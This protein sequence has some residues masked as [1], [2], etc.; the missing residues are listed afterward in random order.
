MLVTAHTDTEIR[1]V[2]AGGGTGGHLYPAIA[3][4]EALQLKLPT[5]TFTFVGTR[6]GI[7]ARVLRKR[8]ENFRTLWV[9]GF[10]R[11][12]L[13][14]NGFA[15]M[16]LTVSLVQSAIILM[17]IRPH[18]AI[19]TGGFVMGPLLFLAQRMRIPTL[20][21][22]QNSVP[23]L[24]TRKLA[25]RADAVCI[26]FTDAE[27]R[28]QTKKTYLTGNPVRKEFG[29]VEQ[30]DSTASFPLDPERKTLLIVGGSLGAQSLNRAVADALPQ[31]VQTYNIIWQTGR[32]GVPDSASRSIIE[33]ATGSGHL[34]ITNFIEEM[35]QAYAASDLAIC[36][37]G[38]MTITEL[39]LCGLPA[40]FIPFP[41]ATD[42]HQ[43][44]NARSLCDK[45]AA[46]LIP[47][48]ELTAETL[49]NN[50]HSILSTPD[51]LENMRTAMLAFAKPQAAEDIADIAIG[52]IRS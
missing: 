27:R 28:L 38:A 9:S 18:I 30:H 25:S 49:L 2:I 40:I 31:L 45:N 36:R 24:T 37:A 13:F 17:R 7:E 39:A 33:H 5:A 6:D 35:P 47:D 11:G 3:I 32:T 21:Q 50:I 23:G 52:L 4:K 14:Q 1:I 48:N 26:A 42:D 44:A 20:L 22:E 51:K 8:A 34:Q 43:T 15:L 12:S 41:F 46:C 19:G 10:K 29:K 16:K